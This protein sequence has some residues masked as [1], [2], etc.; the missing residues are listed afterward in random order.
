MANAAARR[1]GRP[2]GPASNVVRGRSSTWPVHC[3][4]TVI[5]ME[6]EGASDAALQRFAH[7]RRAHSSST[8]EAVPMIDSVSL[9]HRPISGANIALTTAVPRR[10]SSIEP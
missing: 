1:S 3:P 4:M 2:P 10:A 9:N 7:T 5:G 6:R 8:R